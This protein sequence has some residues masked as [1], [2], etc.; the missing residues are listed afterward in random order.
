MLLMI[1]TNSIKDKLE[2][3]SESEFKK[4]LNEFYSDHRSSPS[5]KGDE[6]ENYLDNLLD[7]L[8]VLVGT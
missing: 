6:L 7:M 5:P 1:D 2:S 4:I 3:Y 8:T